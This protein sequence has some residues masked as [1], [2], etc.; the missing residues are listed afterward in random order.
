LLPLGAGVGESVAAG[1]GLD[2]VPAEGEAVDDG[3]AEPGVGEGLGPVAEAVVAGD[4][5]GGFLLALGQDLE[6]Q[7][8]ATLVEFHVAEFVE[9]E[10]FDP[11][12]AGDGPRQ[13]AFISGLDEFVDE[14]GR[15]DVADLVS[16]LGGGGPQADEQVALA[17]AA[18]ADQ[19]ERL[20][21]ADPTAAGEGVDGGSPCRGWCPCGR[22]NGTTGPTRQSGR[23]APPGPARGVARG[24]AGRVRRGGRTW[25]GQGQQR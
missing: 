14:L 20:T 7:F 2:D 24:L 1:P 23:T 12:V 9:A 10:Q 25:S 5:D 3:G 18:V 17:R 19:A 11:A 13:L 15:E 16:G 22:S 21:F 8:G 4:R 6:Q